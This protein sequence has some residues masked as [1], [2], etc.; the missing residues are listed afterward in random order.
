MQNNRDFNQGILHL[1]VQIWWSLPERVKSYRVD[2]LPMGVNFDF[3]IKFDLE[4]LG[5]LST[6]TKG[7]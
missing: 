5:Q 2:K 1:L 7:P 6:K 4:C 3:E